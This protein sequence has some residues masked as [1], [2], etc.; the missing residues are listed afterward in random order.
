MITF[1][2]HSSQLCSEARLLLASGINVILIHLIHV[3]PGDDLV[4][5]KSSTYVYINVAGGDKACYSF[6]TNCT[7]VFNISLL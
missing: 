5:T 4:M 2:M 6:E 7:S 3:Y 1:L